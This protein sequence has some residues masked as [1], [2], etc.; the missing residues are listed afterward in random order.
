MAQHR[1]KTLH[2]LLDQQAERCPDKVAF[3]FEGNTL[4]FREIREQ[5]NQLA[6]W[7]KS[8]GIQ[9][10]DR[11]GVALDRSL[12]LVIALIAVWKTGA[13]HIPLDPEFPRE[14]IR[15]MLEDSSAVLLLTSRRYAG[16]LESPVP[17]AFLEDLPVQPTADLVSD[18]G[19]D[20]LAYILYT[21]GS[22]GKPKG[23]MVEHHNLVNLLYGMLVL[24]GLSVSD[25]VLA[26]TSVTFDIAF[27]ELFLPFLIGAETLIATREVARDGRAMLELMRTKGVTFMQ[28]TPATWKMIVNAG[29]NERLPIR[30]ISTGEAISRQL[31]DQLLERSLEVYNLYGPTE[32]TVYATGRRIF[33]GQERITIGWPLLNTSVYILDAAQNPIQAGETGEI[34]VGGKGV[35]RGYLNR[36]VLTAERFLPDPFSPGNWMYRTGD[37][38]Q[39]S[40][41]G[42]IEY[43][44]RADQQV[45]I[46]GYR[47][48]LGEIE[49]QLRQ[50]EGVKEAVVVTREDQP[51]EPQLVAYLVT[52][53]EALSKGQ[54]IA[55][56]QTLKK[57]LPSY[58]VPPFYVPIKEMPL[59]PSGKVDRNALLKT[60]KGNAIGH[61]HK[62]PR[63][64]LEKEVAEV[65]QTVLDIEEIDVDD[66]FFDLGGHSLI[67]LVMMTMLEER[68]GK[69]LPIASLF[70][71]PTI[72]QLARLLESEEGVYWGSLV[73]IKPTGT[74]PPL[75]I[76]HG[77]GLEVMIFHGLARQLD[78]E[79]PVF[80]IQARGLNGEVKPQRTMEEI[81]ASYIEEILTHNATGPYCLAGYSMGGLIVFEMARQLRALGRELKLL[82]V[83]DTYVG[84]KHP[85]VGLMYKIMQQPRKFLF[86]LGAFLKD[87]RSAVQFHWKTKLGF[88]RRG[89][90]GSKNPEGVV[91]EIVAA[92]KEANINYRLQVNETD[93]L[94]LFRAKKRDEFIYDPVYMGWKPFLKKGVRITEVPGDHH[95]LLQSPN[96]VEVARLLQRILDQNGASNSRH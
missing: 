72:G 27:V 81:A 55:W 25:K 3:T 37:L 68:L 56:Q 82:A 15:F 31:A 92:L 77:L 90:T 24:P 26:I 34:I 65:W 76:V 85:D 93:V 53:W 36:D 80:G 61:S 91:G 51:G 94:E 30:V 40:Q 11:V 74:K 10:G 5:S 49:D 41:Q 35:A 87:P 6:H 7:L 58:M 75:Y 57:S 95:N 9:P 84:D 28:G 71:A 89:K 17:E 86:Y 70:K 83:F 69:K 47:I 52:E 2:V 20:A 22:T 50:L 44:G 48:E 63:T 13:A 12:D 8:L 60:P 59:S 33:P 43:L 45:K 4:T 19:P 32:T 16:Y 39:W 88:A 54:V 78:P 38:G 23:V 96:D 42:D 14:R 79:Q 1:D 62:P 66:D 21:S 46:R 67:A 64:R 18:V 29:W 73:P